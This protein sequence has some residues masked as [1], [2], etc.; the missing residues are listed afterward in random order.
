[1]LSSSASR[2]WSGSQ[3]PLYF[4]KPDRA[5]FRTSAAYF[6]ITAQAEVAWAVKE[7]VT[8][9]GGAFIEEQIEV[10][11]LHSTAAYARMPRDDAQGKPCQ[12][13]PCGA[14]LLPSHQHLERSKVAA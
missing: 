8:S 6:P 7:G 9:R 3:D 1:M 4:A 12:R 14:R 10:G 5:L 13:A 11:A 2:R